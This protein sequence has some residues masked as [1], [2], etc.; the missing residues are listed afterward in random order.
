[1]ALLW[2]GNESANMA[3]SVLD[4]QQS[5]EKWKSIESLLP[6]QYGRRENPAHHPNDHPKC[7]LLEREHNSSHK[8]AFF[9]VWV[10]QGKLLQIPFGHG[11]PDSWL[12][13]SFHS[14]SGIEREE[15]QDSAKLDQLFFWQSL[16]SHEQIESP[17]R[18]FTI[19]WN[20]IQIKRPQNHLVE[21][22]INELQNIRHF[23]WNRCNDDSQTIIYLL[24]RAASGTSLRPH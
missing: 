2:G 19:S 9:A 6:T 11:I 12:L 10:G 13:D 8:L 1:M 15:Y 17:V 18:N 14:K 7:N 20:F 4:L 21:N 22:A 24:H 3:I 23:R 5:D 16:P